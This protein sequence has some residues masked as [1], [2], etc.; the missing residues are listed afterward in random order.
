MK[1]YTRVV[2]SILAT[3]VIL[4]MLAAQCAAPATPETVVETV[5]VK[6]TVEVEKEVVKEVEKVVTQEVEVEVEVVVTATPEPMAELPTSI[7]IVDTNSGANFQWYWQNQVIPAIEDQLGIKVDYVV[8]KEAEL[9]ER[10]K[11]WEAGEGDSHLLFV[12]PGTIPK[13]LGEGIELETLYPE[14][15]DVVPNMEKNPPAYRARP[16]TARARCIGGASTR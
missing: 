6:E 3:V 4:S 10:M 14:K 1:N 7:T 9:I 15:L 13:A 16:S 5:V 12:K 11:A 2:F 8:S